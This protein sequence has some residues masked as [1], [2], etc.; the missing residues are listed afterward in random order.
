MGP[1]GNGIVGIYMNSQTFTNVQ[2]GSVSCGSGYLA[3]GGGA[4]LNDNPTNLNTT[5]P[6]VVNGTP[7]G[8]TVTYS[9]RASFVVHVVCAR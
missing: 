8:W 5:S 1:T 7:T 4:T 2:T 6:V 9:S 3:V